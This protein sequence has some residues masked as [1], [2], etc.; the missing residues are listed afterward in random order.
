M[1]STRRHLSG[2]L[3]ANP[4]ADIAIAAA[5]GFAGTLDIQHGGGV[6]LARYVSEQANHLMGYMS[7]DG[8]MA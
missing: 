2:I 3:I 1:S 5:K 4:Q 6:S 8:Q 7:R